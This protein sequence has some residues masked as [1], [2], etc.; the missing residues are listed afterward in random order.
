MNLNLTEKQEELLNQRL[1]EKQE[2]LDTYISS[3]IIKDIEY[4]YVLGYGFY[5]NK[6]LKKL[7]DKNNKE[8]KLATIE[9]NVLHYFIKKNIEK[10]SPQELYEM[11]WERKN[12][13]FSI[14]TVRNVIKRLRDKTHYKLIKNYSNLGYSI[15]PN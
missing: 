9:M 2:S 7:Y 13:G 1:E 11:C 14:H 12:C 3:L 5:Y 10:I 8:I 6:I 4:K 15:Y